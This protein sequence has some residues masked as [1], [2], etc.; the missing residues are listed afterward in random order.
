MRQSGY[1]IK[2]LRSKGHKELWQTGRSA[3]IRPDLRKRIANR[4]EVLDSALALSDLRGFGV[5]PLKGS[6]R[7]R[8][9]MEVNGPWRITF[10]FRDGDAYLVDL[11]Q[12]H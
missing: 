4:L 8:Y 7:Q 12:Y 1:V 11:E 6:G 9:S 10:E 2:S 3:S 5:H